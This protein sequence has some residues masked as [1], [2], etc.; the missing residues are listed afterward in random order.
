[1]NEQQE[2]P[3]GSARGARRQRGGVVAFLVGLM[4]GLAFFGFFP[5]LPHVIDA[6]AILVS[7]IV[8][9]LARWGWQAWY[10]RSAGK[11]QSHHGDAG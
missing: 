4:A 6:G 1:M 10:D 7:L 8:G 9:A 5:G 3:P 11:T 2:R